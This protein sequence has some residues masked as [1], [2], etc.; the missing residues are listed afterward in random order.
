MR[1]TVKSPFR[2]GAVV[3]SPIATLLN[4]F[5]VAEVNYFFD[6]FFFNLTNEI[7][8]RAIN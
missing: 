5:T 8:E 4:V 1:D 6:L 3:S 2:A 7:L